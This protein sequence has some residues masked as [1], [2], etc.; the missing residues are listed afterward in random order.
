MNEKRESELVRKIRFVCQSSGVKSVVLG[1]SGG[2]DS[3]A[4]LYLFDKSGIGYIPVHC[5]F[6]L[7][8]EESERD[9]HSVE[10]HCERL[11]KELHCVEFDTRS[12]MEEK[13]VSLEVAC[14]ELRYAEFRRIM[15]QTSADRIAVAHNADDNVETLLLNLFRGAGTTGLRGMKPDTGEIIRPLLDIT[16]KEIEDFLDHEGIEFVVDSTNLESDFRRN[17]L[18]NDIIPLIETRWPGVKKAIGK[19]IE[20]L[21]GEEC[22]LNWAQA[23]LVGDC[24][25]FLPMEILANSPDLLWTIRCFTAPFGTKRDIMLEIVDVF[26]KR[27]G[28][29]HIIG[30]SWKAGKGKLTFTKKGLSYSEDEG[31]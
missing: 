31:N 20:N 15:R 7:R 10:K 24:G 2:A 17:F 21:R 22:V 23:E 27:Y 25:N 5:N 9:M 30:K 19:S 8:G 1:V 14:R 6:H 16:R 3:T 11:G 28:S 29:Q 4:L 26:K 13:G 12:Y 18:R